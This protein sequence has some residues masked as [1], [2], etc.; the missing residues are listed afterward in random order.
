MGDYVAGD[1]NR[2][3]FV[4]SNGVYTTLD[5]PGSL[6]TVAEGINNPGQIAGLYVDAD[7][8]QHGFVLCNG[9]YT[10]IDVPGSVSTGVFSI[11]ARRDRGI[12]DDATAPTATSGRL[13]TERPTPQSRGGPARSGAALPSDAN[14]KRTRNPTNTTLHQENIRCRENTFPLAGACSLEALEDR[15][16]LSSLPVGTSTTVPDAATQAHLTAAYGQLPLSFEVN[17][18]QTDPRVNFLAR[19]PATRR[20]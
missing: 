20:S 13:P 1:G 9:V 3:G 10:T 4:L 15:L 12:F 16:C 14:P 11:N 18:G 8:N 7:G 6:L 17:K 5:V 19:A 2:R